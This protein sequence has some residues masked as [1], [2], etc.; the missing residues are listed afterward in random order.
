MWKDKEE[1]RKDEWDGTAERQCRAERRGE[2]SR[3]GMRADPRKREEKRRRT[4]AGNEI[5][6]MEFQAASKM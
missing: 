6:Q 3:G 4:V 5:V 1:D 2:G